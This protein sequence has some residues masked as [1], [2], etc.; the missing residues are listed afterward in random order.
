MRIPPMPP[1]DDRP[2]GEKG[3]V[4]LRDYFAAAAMTGLLAY[5]PGGIDSHYAEAAYQMA[6]AMLEAR[7]NTV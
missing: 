5:K 2:D 1:R 4:S 6:D 7:A 3:F